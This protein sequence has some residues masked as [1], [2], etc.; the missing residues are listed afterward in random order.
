MKLSDAISE[1]VWL[2]KVVLPAVKETNPIVDAMTPQTAKA[3]ETAI[4][5]LEK[6]FARRI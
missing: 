3:L 6:D 1:L 5:A 2:Q 4:S